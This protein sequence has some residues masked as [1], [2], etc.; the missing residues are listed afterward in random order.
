MQTEAK[1]LFFAVKLIEFIF[2]AV[3]A[4]SSP[5]IEPIPS[6]NMSFFYYQYE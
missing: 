5:C 1:F 3:K 2:S 4:C 6:I